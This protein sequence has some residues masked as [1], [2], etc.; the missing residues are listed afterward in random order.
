MAVSTPVDFIPVLLP[1]FTK[2]G[3]N[4]TESRRR[5]EDRPRVSRVPFFL[6]LSLSTPPPSFFIAVVLFLARFTPRADWRWIGGGGGLVVTR[7]SRRLHR[8]W[9][10]GALGAAIKLHS[11]GNVGTRAEQIRRQRMN[12]AGASISRLFRPRVLC[13]FE[14]RCACA[15]TRSSSETASIRIIYIR[16]GIVKRNSHSQF[17]EIFKVRGFWKIFKARINLKK[18]KNK[19]ITILS[20]SKKYP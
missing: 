10:T 9:I 7:G 20:L 2:G 8:C 13:P 4:S 3:Q 5:F 19:K 11:G 16:F 18:G 17:R 15:F 12:V 6:F 1:L 14:I